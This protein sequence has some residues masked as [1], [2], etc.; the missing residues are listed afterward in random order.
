MSVFENTLSFFII[1]KISLKEQ[2][3]FFYS[4]TV[5]AKD[6]DSGIRKVL[7]KFKVEE[8]GEIRSE[9]EFLIETK[10]F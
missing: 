4:V 5:S 8:T 10:V 3:L 2:L 6:D 9:K 7:F 1:F